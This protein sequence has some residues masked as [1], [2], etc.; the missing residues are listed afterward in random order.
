[1]KRKFFFGIMA[2]AFLILIVPSIS[3]IEYHTTIVTN[4]AKLQENNFIDIAAILTVFNLIIARLITGFQGNIKGIIYTA[5]ITLS[6]LS[7]IKL[8]KDEYKNGMSVPRY[9]A[10]QSYFESL[11]G[12]LSILVIKLLP[13]NFPKITTILSEI[14]LFITLFLS[15]YLGNKLYVVLGRPS[16]SPLGV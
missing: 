5:E 2:V 1:M 9:K 11:F 8:I 15:K 14:L 16:G 12:I 10:Y 4:I 3:A 13:K 6:I 7:Y